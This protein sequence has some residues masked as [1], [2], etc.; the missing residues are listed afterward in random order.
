M[1]SRPNPLDG[2]T[3]D[4]A[5]IRYVGEG[6]QRPE[7]ILAERDGS[8]WSADA[9]GGVVHIRPDGSQAL[10]TQTA[11]RGFAEAADEEARFVSGTLP[12]GLAFAGNGDILISTPAPTGWRS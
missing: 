7:C 4:P 5:A 9:R 11:S 1:S 12:N 6:L 8:L 10:I 2:F 3:V